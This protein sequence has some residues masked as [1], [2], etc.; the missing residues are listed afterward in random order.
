MTIWSRTARMKAGMTGR[1]LT[2]GLS[3]AYVLSRLTR[4][5]RLPY[6][7]L[8]EVRRRRDRRIQNLTCYAAATVPYYRELLQANGLDL[9]DI[10][11]AADLDRL[12]LLDKAMVR[13]NPQR[14]VAQSV[15]GRRSVSS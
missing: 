14:F 8:E 13:E 15:R 2:R 10:R 4:E 1:L 6:L 11:S 7:P 3:T 9:R 12:P 5:R